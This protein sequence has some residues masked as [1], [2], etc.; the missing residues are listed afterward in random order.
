MYF[1]PTGLWNTP[2]PGG[3]TS[4]AQKTPLAT[5]P[6]TMTKEETY[7]EYLWRERTESGEEVD[8]TSTTYVEYPVGYNA[9]LDFDALTSTQSNIVQDCNHL[10]AGLAPEVGQ[11]NYSLEVLEF[12][13]C[14]KC[15]E[16][17]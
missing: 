15:G 16:K 17:L 8:K 11:S 12:A 1:T 3:V 2:T 10:Y 5:A 4:A 13:Y 6:V 9:G 14:P 7:A